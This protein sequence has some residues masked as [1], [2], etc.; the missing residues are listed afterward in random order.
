MTGLEFIG[1]VA[2]IELIAKTPIIMVTTEGTEEKIAQAKAANPYLAGYVC[3]PFTPEQ[4]K[5]AIAPI[6]GSG[7]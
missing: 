2:K 5:S 7:G 1:A 4:L 3:K 6:F